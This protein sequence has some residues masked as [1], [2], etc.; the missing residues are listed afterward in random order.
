LAG[1]GKR[2]IAG[3]GRRREA[4]GGG[5]ER[6]SKRY[7]RDSARGQ[8]ENE[9]NVVK[10]EKKASSFFVRTTALPHFTY[11]HIPWYSQHYKRYM[12]QPTL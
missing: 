2:E 1:S 5:V 4:R 9:L 10:E 3:T 8:N 11:I 6:G 12:V 7:A